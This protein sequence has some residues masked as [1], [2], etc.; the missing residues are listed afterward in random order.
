AYTVRLDVEQR[1]AVGL[2]GVADVGD[3]AAGGPHDLP[4]CAAGRQQFRMEVGALGAS[5]GQRDD[6]AVTLWGVAEVDGG[7]ELGVEAVDVPEFG[8]W[9]GGHGRL[10][11]QWPALW[12]PSTC[13]NS[14]VTNG[15][16]SR[17]MTALTTS[18]VSP[19]RPIGCSVPMPS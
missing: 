7:V 11:G 1:P 8:G 3:R 6:A 4:V 13:M 12:P 10:L 15:A 5:A 9:E 14:P 2:E 16:D 19:M 18:L 17:Y